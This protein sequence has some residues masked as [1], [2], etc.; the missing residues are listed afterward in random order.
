MSDE[1]ENH[2]NHGGAV[3]VFEPQ[4]KGTVL[5]GLRELAEGCRED[6]AVGAFVVVAVPSPDAIGLDLDSFIHRK[7]EPELGERTASLSNACDELAAESITKAFM[8][9]A[10]CEVCRSVQITTLSRALAR[11]SVV[12]TEIAKGL[13]TDLAE[14]KLA[15]LKKRAN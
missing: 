10:H 8:V 15:E 3:S 2:E 4:G 11:A 14:R 13:A 7:D 5:S 6:A 9:T 12:L 1:N